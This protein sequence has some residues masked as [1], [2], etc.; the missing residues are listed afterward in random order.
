MEFITNPEGVQVF[1]SPWIDLDKVYRNKI[2]G[3][4]YISEQLEYKLLIGWFGIDKGVELCIKASRK[5]LDRI[6]AKY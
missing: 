5:H 2:N 6:L 3:E 1:F 4:L